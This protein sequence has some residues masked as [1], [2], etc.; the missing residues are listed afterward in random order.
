[1]TWAPTHDGN[2]IHLHMELQA[3]KI[4]WVFWSQCLV[5]PT[6]QLVRIFILGGYVLVQVIV[7]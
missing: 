3:L 4:A 2:H 7:I 5:L 1:M 6:K